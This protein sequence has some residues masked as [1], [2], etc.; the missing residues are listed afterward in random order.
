MNAPDLTGEILGGRYRIVKAIG[1]GGMG[2]VYEAVQLD[3]GRAV[4]VKV[5]A[6]ELADEPEFLE[7]F[8]REAVAAAQL[9]HPNIVEVTDFQ[10]PAGEPPFLVM[11][12]LQGEP[13]TASLKRGALE[14]GRAVD[15]I[16]Q[17]LAGLDAAHARG[18]VHRDLKPANIFLVPIGPDRSLVKLVDFGIAK[19]M[20]SAMFDRLTQTGML[21]GTPR[22]AAPEQITDSKSVDPR[23][24]VYAAG[25]LLYCM[26]A[27]RP[28]F[29]SQGA[30]L[31]V[32]I[33]TE[34]PPPIGSFT[35]SVDPAL[36]EIVRRAM[37]KRREQ[38]FP[39]AKAF[40]DALEAF[41]GGPR[42]GASPAGVAPRSSHPPMLTPPTPA[43][44][45]ERPVHRQPAAP[46]TRAFRAPPTPAPRHSPAPRRAAPAPRYPTPSPRYAAPRHTPAPRYA[47]PR[48]T[49]APRYAAPA[50]RYPTPSPRWSAPASPPARGRSAALWVSLGVVGAALLGALVAGGA[51]LSGLISN[52]RTSGGDPEASRRPP[53]ELAA[54]C[55]EWERMACACPDELRREEHCQT[56]RASLAAARDGTP[57]NCQRWLERMQF[58]CDQPARYEPTSLPD[59]PPTDI[60]SCDALG[61][62]ACSCG[63]GEQLA[64][65]CGRAREFLRW[66]TENPPSQAGPACDRERVIIERLCQQNP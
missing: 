21:I 65:R 7:R 54:S 56:A 35:P 19:L 22:Y 39:S 42:A 48:H 9:G 47:A 53:V 8:R 4:A 49:P 28:P 6:R 13:L 38:R 32:D 45:G 3:L 36:T 37:A 24:D 64:A 27:G 62:F 63:T 58:L 60:P 66:S 46:P 29:L 61:R 23:S 55:L 5:I 11:E 40:A 25:V 52:P 12:L 50:P 57:V 59:P 20:D 18:I 14:P 17:V 43:T 30:R 34:E 31:L 33:E 2:G 16:V 41:S 26:L 10:H 15:I 44:R 1:K 51:Y